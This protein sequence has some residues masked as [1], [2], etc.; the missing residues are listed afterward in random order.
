MRKPLGRLVEC[1]FRD[2]AFP[3]GCWLM[4]GTGIVPP[5]RFC[6]QPGDEVRITIQPIGTLVNTMR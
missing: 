2:N 1:L 3:C 5:G 6:L 4:T